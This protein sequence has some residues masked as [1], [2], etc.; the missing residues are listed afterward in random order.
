MIHVDDS[1]LLLPLKWARECFIPVIEQ[2]F[3]ITY[4]LAYEVGHSFSFLKR[5]HTITSDG[6]VIRQPASYIE[7]MKTIMDHFVLLSVAQGTT[8]LEAAKDMS[9]ELSFED[10]SKYRQ[11]VGTATMVFR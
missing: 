9:K 3:Q 2:R 10:A 7:Q 5:L 6:I 4:E 8:S 1:L 11:A